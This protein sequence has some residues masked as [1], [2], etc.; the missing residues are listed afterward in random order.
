MFGCGIGGRVRSWRVGGDRAIVN[1]AAALR[2]LAFHE[3]ESF[4]SAEERT[5]KINIDHGFPLFVAQ[6]FKRDA[7]R[8]HTSVIEQHIEPTKYLFS[9]REQSTHRG[10][11]ADVSRNRQ[12][13]TASLS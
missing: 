7:R 13:T 2:V 1:N 11:I 3:L 4:L 12:R 8:A 6:I 10:R 9:P 5:G